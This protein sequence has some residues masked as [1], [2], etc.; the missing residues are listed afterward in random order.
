MS[1]PRLV[2][3]LTVVIL[4]FSA[5]V[6]AAPSATKRQS[7]ATAGRCS[8][9]A[10]RKIV[11]QLGL[12]DQNVAN[13][14]YKVLC[15]SFTG[16]GSQTMVVLLWGEGNSGVVEWVVFRWAGGTWQ[17]LMKQPTPG[18]ITAAGPDI[19]Q[20]LPIYRPSDPRCCPTGGTKSRI[21]HWNG[22]RFVAGPWEQQ[23]AERKR[24]GFYSPSRNIA[25]GM[26]DDGRYRYVNCQ[27]RRPP[28]NVTLDATGRVKICRDPTPNNVTNECNIGDPGEGVI[29]VLAYGK[30][31]TIGRFRCVSRET[32]VTCTVITSGKGFV[33]NRDGVR[34]VGP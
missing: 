16:P 18:S 10:A 19:R 26:F 14:V 8:K 6:A 3:C 32:G 4:A 1:V 2:A 31:I 30:Q 11:E 34:R 17:F 7:S 24:A 22:S 13:P 33:I 25:C 28:Q 23:G 27:S 15:G 21:W 5:T 20:T 29:P 9:A 12:N